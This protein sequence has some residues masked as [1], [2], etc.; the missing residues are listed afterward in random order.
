[1]NDVTEQL[2]DVR[3]MANEAHSLAMSIADLGQHLVD[4][5]MFHAYIKARA[6]DL[7]REAMLFIEQQH[8]EKQEAANG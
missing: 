7:E 5:G 8:A 4:C 6:P 3:K 2:E 1:M